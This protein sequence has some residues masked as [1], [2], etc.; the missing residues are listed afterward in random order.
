MHARQDSCYLETIII[1][2]KI[3]NEMPLFNTFL[4]H[5][6]VI[7][8][9]NESFMFA[10]KSG[11][12]KTTHIKKWLENNKDAYVVN[13]DKPLI[14][15]TEDNV[16]ACGTPWCGKEYLGNNVI[17]PLKSI[18]LMERGEDNRMEKI[19]FKQAYLDLL[20]QTYLPP[21]ADNARK[22]LS[23]LSQLDGK[24]DFWKFT[25]NNFKDDCFSI[26][27]HELCLK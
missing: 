21:D 3:C 20:Q 10:A 27:Y 17:V 16:M 24:V 8:V 14:R 4:M 23:L 15:I 2:R 22:T 11:T 25:F 5:G 6:A 1:Y 19:T 12:G 9:G 13:G 26:S 7:A 18:V